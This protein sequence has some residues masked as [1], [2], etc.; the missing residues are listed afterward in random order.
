MAL[1]TRIMYKVR[2]TL[3]SFSLQ[4]PM[5][6]TERI[7]KTLLPIQYRL[8]EPLM[9]IVLYLSSFGSRKTQAQEC[10]PFHCNPSTLN[11]QACRCN[12]EYPYPCLQENHNRAIIETTNSCLADNHE[13]L[14]DALQSFATAFDLTGTG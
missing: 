9:H 3:Q 12:P 11:I 8:P 10:T 5:T 1:L 14:V 6:N 2:R 4:L 13:A 7:I